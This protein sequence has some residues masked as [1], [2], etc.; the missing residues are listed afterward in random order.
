M[1]DV[2]MPLA[3]LPSAHIVLE[4]DIPTL[5]LEDGQEVYTAVCKHKRSIRS[6]RSAGEPRNLNPSLT[7][8]LYRFRVIWCCRVSL[9]ELTADCWSEGNL[10]ACMHSSRCWP[11]LWLKE[12]SELGQRLISNSKFLSHTYSSLRWSRVKPCSGKVQRT[13]KHWFGAKVQPEAAMSWPRIQRTKKRGT[14]YVIAK[15]R[16]ASIVGIGK[17]YLWDVEFHPAIP[18]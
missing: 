7:H 11:C 4:K 6:E 3:A 5:V 9:L 8:Y 12:V 1:R 18:S 17:S 14:E 10:G 13:R 16:F 2:V 15:E